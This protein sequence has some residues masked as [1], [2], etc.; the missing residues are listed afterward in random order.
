MQT[1]KDNVLQDVRFQGCVPPKGLSLTL[2]MAL[3]SVKT[4]YSNSIISACETGKV[5]G[6]AEEMETL[7]KSVRRWTGE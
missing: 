4:D 6:T 1:T 5:W 7:R 3:K 2:M